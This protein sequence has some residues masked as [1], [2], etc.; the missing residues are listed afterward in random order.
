[1]PRESKELLSRK[2]AG[3]VLF[4]LILVLATTGCAEPTSHRPHV[5]LVMVDTLRADRLGVY[6]YGRG[7]TP[8]LDRWAG[9]HATVFRDA[10]ATGA[11]TLPSAASILTGL[12]VGQHRVG[13]GRN[14]LGEADRPLAQRLREAGYETHGFCEGGPMGAALGFDT[15][16]DI[17]ECDSF[18]NFP[19][20]RALARFEA[21]RADAPLFLFLQM[22]RVHTP[23]EARAEW[24]PFAGFT[25]RFGGRFAGRDVGE[26]DY[27]AIR[28]GRMRPTR[29]EMAYV[30]HLYDA[31][32]RRLD[33]ELGAF[34]EALEVSAA[35]EELLVIVTSDHGEEF[36]EH[37]MVGHG[38]SL[39]G[40]LLR[41]PLLVRFPDERRGVEEMPVSTL[42]IAPTILEAAKLPVPE[43]FRG[44]PLGAPGNDQRVRVAEEATVGRAL[45]RGS[46]KWI[47]IE[48]PGGRQSR[49]HHLGI[50]PQE[51]TNLAERH[52]AALA[53]LQRAAEARGS[54]APV[55]AG[56]LED[57]PFSAE[58]RR[59]L[60]AL[61]Y[62]DRRPEAEPPPISPT[63]EGPA[64]VIG[65]QP[66]P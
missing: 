13:A 18:Q 63:S 43:D 40:E 25:G 42:D 16:F 56:V 19:W 38:H 36:F 6:G 28:L 47:E 44:R 61:G 53:S 1:M 50:D 4:G 65:S 45:Q 21:R 12:E 31:A 26:L 14:R 24:L 7:T 20:Q 55:S 22:Y 8:H 64:G 15:G 46:L 10:L 52:P 41:V 11:W 48:T 51:R 60:E 59:A 54:Q 35:G 9:D 23:L 17:Y 49:L 39:F 37:G 34:L 5:V 57:E 3:R 62:G 58:A 29:E 2:H 66:R 27:E 30:S 32:V 33:A